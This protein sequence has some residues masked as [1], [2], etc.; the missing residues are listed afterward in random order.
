[1][2]KFR[3]FDIR[4]VSYVYINHIIQ[5]VPLLLLRGGFQNLSSKALLVSN[6]IF[7]KVALILISYWNY[8]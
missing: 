4:G 7:G 5:G 1:M 8:V 6:T 3:G 2:S